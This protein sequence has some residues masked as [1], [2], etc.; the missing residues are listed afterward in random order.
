MTT[1]YGSKEIPKQ[2]FGEGTSELNA[3][4][5]AAQQTAPGAW[6]LLQDLLGSWQAFALDH[7]WTLPD[8]FLAKVKV[9]DKKEARIEVDELDHA[10][11]TYEFYE[12]VGKKTGISLPANVVHSVDAY[13]LRC[14]H[15]RCNYDR[16]VVETAKVLITSELET[17]QVS[18]TKP[19][20]KINYYV[21]HYLHSG[22]ADVV[23]LPWLTSNNISQVPVELLKK[24]SE[25]VEG[26]LEYSP[27]E[28]VTIHDEFKCSPNNMNYLRQQ[29][30][31]ILAELAE[32]SVIDSILTQIHKK[33]TTFNKLSN[34]LGQVIRGS[35][36]ALS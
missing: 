32:S 4:Y 11:F 18:K 36:Y 7:S 10:S 29:Y 19:D 22:M 31:N 8:G 34:N 1:F 27:F 23:I 17:P 9:M 5:E 16:K 24:L 28:V 14:I 6:E 13:V 30:I 21:N 3:Y 26:M 25:L 12:N 35:N 2:I 20:D 15:R 33:P